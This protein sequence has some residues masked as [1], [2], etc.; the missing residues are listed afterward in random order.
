[1]FAAGSDFPPVQRCVQRSQSALSAAAAVKAAVAGSA[2][3]CSDRPEWHY[4]ASPAGWTSKEQ[5]TR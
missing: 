3:W 1:M 2:H 5:E 4:G